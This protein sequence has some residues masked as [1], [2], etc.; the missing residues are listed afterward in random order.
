LVATTNHHNQQEFDSV[1]GFKSSTLVRVKN[2][3]SLVLSMSRKRIGKISVL[4]LRV[5]EVLQRPQGHYRTS[6]DTNTPNVVAMKEHPVL[7]AAPDAAPAAV[8]VGEGEPELDPV[9]L[10]EPVALEPE[11]ML[12]VVLAPG[13]ATASVYKAALAVV[14]HFELDGIDGSYGRVTMGPRLSGGWE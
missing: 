1:T 13:A 6:S 14:V 9:R 8:D 2:V 7:I 3:L 11:L 12:A 5:P 10:G 4:S